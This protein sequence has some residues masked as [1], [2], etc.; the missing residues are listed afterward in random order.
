[1]LNESA[2]GARVVVDRKHCQEFREI[3]GDAKLFDKKR[4]VLYS[5]GQVEL[6]I[7]SVPDPQLETKLHHLA[8][9]SYHL[10]ISEEEDP[11]DSIGVLSL[12]EKLVLSVSDLVKCS[13]SSAKPILDILS[14]PCWTHTDKLSESSAEPTLKTL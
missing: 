10:K 3:L 9:G 4:K 7:L 8:A 13:E 6:P 14:E 5:G 1:M 12:R 11:Q 2:A